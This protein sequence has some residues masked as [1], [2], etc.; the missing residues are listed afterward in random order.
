MESL[1]PGIPPS[2]IPEMR[3]PMDIPAVR[4]K[5]GLVLG[6]G[7]YVV[8]AVNRERKN[9]DLVSIEGQP[10]LLEKIPFSALRRLDV[11]GVGSPVTCS[12][13]PRLQS[14]SYMTIRLDS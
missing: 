10:Y 4:E 8:V 9:V 6:N 12:P 11:P 5:V 1:A 13:S 7:V 14:S 3:P 2:G